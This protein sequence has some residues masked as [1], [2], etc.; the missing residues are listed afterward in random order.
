[1]RKIIG[2]IIFLFLSNSLASFGNENIL[3]AIYYGNSTTKEIKRVLNTEKTK[4]ILFEKSGHH[5]QPIKPNK[6]KKSKGVEPV[7]YFICDLREQSIFNS[8]CSNS[9]IFFFSQSKYHF[10][11]PLCHNERGPPTL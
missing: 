10:T 4:V 3:H 5:K 1:M 8:V 2:I 11:I 7:H 6:K 9:T